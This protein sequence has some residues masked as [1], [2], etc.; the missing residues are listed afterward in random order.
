MECDDAREPFFQ[1]PN[2]VWLEIFE[3]VD[4]PQLR[5]LSLVC[6][7]WNSLIFK[8]MT[9]RFMLNFDLDQRKYPRRAIGMVPERTYK[10]LCLNSFK[11]DSPVYLLDTVKQ[12]AVN[13][14]SLKLDLVS[15]ECQTLVQ[16]L[17]LC[18]RMTELR[19]KAKYFECDDTLYQPRP[20]L[21]TVKSLSFDV[22]NYVSTFSLFSFEM[23]FLRMLPNVQKLQ[24]V[25]YRPLDLGLLVW[26][27][28]RLETLKATVYCNAINNFLGVRLPVLKTLD[29]TLLQP[30]QQWRKRRTFHAR[31]FG[32][33]LRGCI[34]L[35]T[36]LL[37]F[38][39]EYDQQL[40][41]TI[42]TSLPWVEKL[43]LSGGLAT[44]RFSLNGMERMKKLKDLSL[45]CLLLFQEEQRIVPMPTVEK[46]SLCSFIR[47]NRFSDV[48][49]R[50]PNLRTLSF[51]MHGDELQSINEAVPLLEDLSV[52]IGRITPD[53]INHLQQL[54][55]LKKLT[56]D[57]HMIARVSMTFHILR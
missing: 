11:L 43:Q 26:M 56:I 48:L 4:T 32:E 25:I 45:H 14:V 3:K 52:D 53:M 19:I 46:F 17:P 22:E 31:S 50:F 1:L 6:K 21:S 24:L 16:L 34:M 37:S 39:C 33:F 18:T 13:L 28:P 7:H 2:E 55:G 10:N 15:L 54:D 30:E 8:H 5:D 35:K 27:A 47:P 38:R 49:K 23:S 12:L 20:F 44:E 40:L 51:R 57:A 29:L 42:F 9:H 36:A 41:T